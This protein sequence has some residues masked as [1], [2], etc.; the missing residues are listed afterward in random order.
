LRIIDPGATPGGRPGAQPDHSPERQSLHVTP[1]GDH[2]ECRTKLQVCY[3]VIAAMTNRFQY[4]VVATDKKR[5]FVPESF[6]CFYKLY[7]RHIERHSFLNRADTVE[8]AKTRRLYAL[9]TKVV[10]QVTIMV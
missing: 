5:L 6:L 4:Y 9:L 3:N 10:I 7:I 1:H 2:L 8:H